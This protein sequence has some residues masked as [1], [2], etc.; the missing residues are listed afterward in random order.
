MTDPIPSPDEQPKPDLDFNDALAQL[1]N[2]GQLPRRVVRRSEVLSQ[3]QA[4]AASRLETLLKLKLLGA[5]AGGIQVR[6][7]ALICGGSGAGKTTAVRLFGERMGLPLAVWTV[8]GWIP[9]GARQEP[10]SLE[11]IG[12]FV[13]INK[14]GIIFL[15]E[16]DK[17]TRHLAGEQY[18]SAS[19]TQEIFALLDADDRLGLAFSAED[20][21]KLR[22]SYL[23]VAA[24]AWQHHWTEAIKLNEVDQAR[25]YAE[26]VAQD[27]GLPEELFFRF[28]RPLLPIMPPDVGELKEFISRIY[29]DLS[30]S[31]PGP[32]RLGELAALALRSGRAMRFLEDFTTQLLAESAS[33]HSV[34]ELLRHLEQ[35][36]AAKANCYL[37]ETKAE[38]Q[39][40]LSKSLRALSTGLEHVGHDLSQFLKSARESD[41]TPLYS[42]L[43]LDPSDLPVGNVFRFS[44]RDFDELPKVDDMEGRLADLP[45][46]RHALLTELRTVFASVGQSTVKYLAIGEGF[47]NKPDESRI[48]EYGKWVAERLTELLDGPDQPSLSADLNCLLWRYVRQHR[49]WMQTYLQLVAALG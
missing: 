22:K 8:G 19:V 42:A 6:T 21:A 7:H 39:R 49:A 41:W 40:R 13:R 30:I 46:H 16:I 11:Q 4:E 20:R 12:R 32:D 25:A 47:L 1:K 28:S 31:A 35:T 43:A 23:I 29:A 38:A 10:N 15:D 33:A 26:L 5:S 9:S 45:Q 36:G 18:W 24:G 27:S 37:G 14:A 48:V 2:G 3:S 44:Q 34:P 17:L